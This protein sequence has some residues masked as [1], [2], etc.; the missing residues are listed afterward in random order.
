MRL[1]REETDDE[2]DDGGTPMWRQMQADMAAEMPQLPTRKRKAATVRKPTGQVRRVVIAAPKR[3]HGARVR[4]P[5]EAFVGILLL[6]LF[7]PF[8]FLFF[9]TLAVIGYTMINDAIT[10]WLGF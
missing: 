10:A 4:D 8:I 7:G 3:R 9:A 6:V 5:N 1:S 2:F